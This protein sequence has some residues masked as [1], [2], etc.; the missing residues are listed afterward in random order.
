MSLA[1]PPP[2]LE[3]II[4][5][6]D[7]EPTVLVPC[8]GFESGEWRRNSLVAHAIEWLPEF[9]LSYSEWSNISHESAVNALARAAQK[10][11]QSDKSASRGELGELLLH[12]VLRQHWG[13]VP[14]ISK[15]HFKDGPNET[16]KGFDSFHVS[17]DSEGSFD[18]WMGESKLYTD[19]KSAIRNVA[20]E[21]SDH[22]ELGYLKN[23]F[24]FILP[25]LDNQWEHTEAL[26]SLL[27]KNTSLDL[28][29]PLIHIPVFI[30]FDSSAVAANSKHGEQYFEELNSEILELQQYFN[31]KSPSLSAEVSIHLIFLPV[32][33]KKELV[34]RWDTSLSVLQ[35]VLK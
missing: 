27:G 23:E 25:K 19:G 24:S 6:T 4:E 9:A 7:S 28:I 35:E 12:I 18:L 17:V 5:S 8:A 20:T 15:I 26:S 29:F 32:K 22:M 30:T 13:T 31:S 16:V 21:I 11:H 10:I 33:N 14:A 1:I 3:F 2:F 34:Q